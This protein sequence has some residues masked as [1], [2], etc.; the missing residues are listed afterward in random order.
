ME[1]ILSNK[2][3]IFVGPLGN[4]ANEYLKKFHYVIR[5]NGFFTV[6]KKLLNSERCDI[7]VVNKLYSTM[8][9]DVIIKNL[10]KVKYVF[11][12]SVLGYNCLLEYVPSQLKNKIIYMNY[13]AYK[14]DFHIK[15]YP[16]LLS[17][18]LL[19]ITEYYTPK[20]FFVTGIDFYVT[21]N[22]NKF[23]LPGYAVKESTE[24]NILAKNKNK[25]DVE[26]NKQF[27]LFLINKYDWVRADNLILSIIKKYTPS[28]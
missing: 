24:A 1:N 11:V 12:S 7:L 25:H 6:D 28:I 8:Y 18:L 20:L 23:W 19:F 21:K 2:K 13:N 17:R 3:I 10:K 14:Q 26:S 16:L 4:P 5:T 22:L 27:L 9:Y 15:K